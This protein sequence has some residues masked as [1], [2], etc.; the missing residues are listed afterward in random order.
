MDGEVEEEAAVEADEAAVA[1]AREWAA[2]V[3][4]ARR[5]PWDARLHLV[6]APDQVA[7]CRGRQA[8]FRARQVE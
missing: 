7:G 8:V 5:R 2:V 3:C 4:R 6:A 1:V